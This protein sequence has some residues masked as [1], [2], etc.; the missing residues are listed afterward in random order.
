M[1]GDV[2]VG[3]IG[4]QGL[5]DHQD[6]FAVRIFAFPEE[7]HAGAE[8]GVARSFFPD[9]LEGIVVEPDVFAAAGEGVLAGGGIEG[10]GTFV[11]DGADI[12]AAG[13]NTERG[14]AGDVRS[15]REGD[16]R[17]QRKPNE[18]STGGGE[19]SEGEGP[20]QEHWQPFRGISD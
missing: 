7:S 2:H 5:A 1:E 4:V 18:Q 17:Q 12:A 11:Q 19:E 6:G 20:A 3:G 13:E 8:D 9:E 15:E 10:G 16:R 14:V